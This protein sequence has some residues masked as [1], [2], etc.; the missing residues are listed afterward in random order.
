MDSM[1]QTKVALAAGRRAAKAEERAT[2][3]MLRDVEKLT[4]QLREANEQAQLFGGNM[5]EAFGGVGE[6]SCRQLHR[7]VARRRHGDG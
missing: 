6:R 5:E 2:A 3:K 1:I 7:R 4:E